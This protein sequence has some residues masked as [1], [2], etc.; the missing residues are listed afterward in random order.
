MWLECP[1]DLPT[2]VE[3]AY[4]GIFKHAAQGRRVALHKK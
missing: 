1:T 3:V 4:L 2:S